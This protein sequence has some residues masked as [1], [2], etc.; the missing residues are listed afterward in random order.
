[1]RNPDM[2]PISPYGAKRA[3]QS[4]PFYISAFDASTRT[5]HARQRD[6]YFWLLCALWQSPSAALPDDPVVLARAARVR[7]NRWKTSVAPWVMPR[8]TEIVPGFVTH[9]T[10]YQLA[11]Q[12]EQW[13]AAQAARKAAG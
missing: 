10:L 2:P 1:M 11:M 8:L 13:L 7:I 5:M 3:R 4:M 6:P 12:R 9:R